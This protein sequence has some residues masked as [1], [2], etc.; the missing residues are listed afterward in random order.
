MKSEG[1]YYLN[2]SSQDCRNSRGVQ[3]IVIEGN[4]CEAANYKILHCT[5]QIVQEDVFIEISDV[6][7]DRT[8]LVNI[9][10]FLGDFCNFD[11]QLSSYPVGFSL[12]A[13]NLDTLKLTSTNEYSIAA[14]D[15]TTNVRRQ[16]FRV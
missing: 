3:A 9:D 10:G 13:R 1:T 12:T 4:P 11:I 6:R 14:M 8:Y 7:S 15:V 2:I 5:P 16:H